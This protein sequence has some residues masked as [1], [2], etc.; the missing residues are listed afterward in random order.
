MFSSGVA[1]SK[2]EKISNNMRI[3]INRNHISSSS[4]HS[5]RCDERMV[6]LL[7]VR[8][9]HKTQ[10]FTERQNPWPSSM[11]NVAVCPSLTQSYDSLAS[12]LD[13]PWTG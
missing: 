7:Q 11:L 8:G 12:T 9:A 13:D 5:C 6:A 1:S 4:K 2:S 3:G 10:C